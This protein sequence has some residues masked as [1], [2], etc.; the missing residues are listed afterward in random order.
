MGHNILCELRICLNPSNKTSNQGKERINQYIN[1]F[2]AFFQYKEILKNYNVDVYITDNTISENDSLPNEILEVIPENVKIITCINNH[3]G[4]FN[5]G[6]GDIEQWRYC[7]SLIEKYKWFIHFEPRQ[8]LLNFNF[9]QN[10]L[11]NPR[12]LFTTDSTNRQFNTGLFCINVKDFF[13][14]INS[15][16]LNIMVQNWIS[17]EKMLF[18][19]VKINK[20]PYYTAS[21]M[22][23][24]WYDTV[25]NKEII[26]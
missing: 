24:I 15:I 16:N 26:M 10:F 18:D 17:I 23:L 11:E 19:F 21:K 5:K 4:C 20:I 2:N 1:G 25:V 13:Y 6:A 3:Y 12:N 9:I 7:K 8:L 22:E 14:F